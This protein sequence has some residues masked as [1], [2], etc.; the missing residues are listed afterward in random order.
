ME[1]FGFSVVGTLDLGESLGYPSS[2]GQWWPYIRFLTLHGPRY[3]E[4]YPIS[5]QRE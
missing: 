4:V 2:A 5:V 1:S 3:K